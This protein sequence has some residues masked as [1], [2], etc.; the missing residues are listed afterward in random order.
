MTLTKDAL[1]NKLAKANGYP[2]NQA[3]ELVETFL[4]LIKLKLAFADDL[5]ISGLGKF[6][7][8]QKDDRRDWNPA[9]CE[10]IT[11]KAGRNVTFK[12]SG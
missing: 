4:E 9:T 11:F 2:R 10:D 12:Y 8:K 7:F 6:S 3:I 5:L 1:I